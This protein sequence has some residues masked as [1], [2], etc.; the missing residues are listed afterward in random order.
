MVIFWLN[1]YT[2]VSCPH[3]VFSYI[4]YSLRVQNLRVFT[5]SCALVYG[6]AHIWTGAYLFK[7]SK[8]FMFKFLFTYEVSVNRTLGP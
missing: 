5:E 7:L 1:K 8:F 4:L 3:Q 6:V 2:L